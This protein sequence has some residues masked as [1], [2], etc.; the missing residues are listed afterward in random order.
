[1]S[2][3]QKSFMLANYRNRVALPETYALDYEH[4][5]N[6]KCAKTIARCCSIMPFFYKKESSR[7][8][9]SRAVVSY[10]LVLRRTKSL[11][12]MLN[13]FCLLSPDKQSKIVN[14]LAQRVRNL[15][16][17][18]SNV[19]HQP[20][21]A[22]LGQGRGPSLRVDNEDLPRNYKSQDRKAIYPP[23]ELDPHVDRSLSE[24]ANV[25]SVEPQVQPIVSHE[26][27]EK[28]ES[29][30]R[31][32]TSIQQ[33]EIADALLRN[34]E[35]IT[36][37]SS[38]RNDLDQMTEQKTALSNKVDTLS[39]N[40]S[41]SNRKIENLMLG[42]PHDIIA[43][44]MLA[45]DVIVD[46]SQ[47]QVSREVFNQKCYRILKN[48]AGT[49]EDLLETIGSGLKRNRIMFGDEIEPLFEVLD[50]LF[51]GD[52]ARAWAVAD[53]PNVVPE[54][55]SKKKKKKKKKNKSSSSAAQNTE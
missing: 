34:Q 49:D 41:A 13:R 11:F 1:M 46:L 4:F 29:Q 12:R 40:L 5:S 19:L 2:F 45:L 6:T 16:K 54:S 38:L 30:L 43:C 53:E 14:S 33:R 20:S 10:A 9:R 24:H 26:E 3:P 35:L 51:A 31:A 15:K 28:T 8:A 50:V 21:A 17:T 42:N 55:S 7:R 25:P 44:L 18:S 27:C 23:I 52:L 48:L 32:V 37:I 47:R 36:T 22:A 39:A